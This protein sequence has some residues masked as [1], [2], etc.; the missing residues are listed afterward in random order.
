MRYEDFVN[1]YKVQL[2]NYLEP[3]KVT[4]TLECSNKINQRQEVLAVRF[5]NNNIAPI[6]YIENEFEKYCNG[7]SIDELVYKSAAMLVDANK[8]SKTIVEKT[9]EYDKENLYVV[10][11]NA[12]MNKEILKDVPHRI[13]EDLAVVPRYSLTDEASYI[14]KENLLPM[15]NMT[16]EELL[17]KAIANTHS[18]GYSCDTLNDVVYK[19]SG[20]DMEWSEPEVYVV[21][22][23]RGHD[24][25]IAV[26]D[27]DYMKNVVGEKLGEDFYI[28]PSSRHE[29]L[30]MPCSMEQD[31]DYIR[32][33]VQSINKEIVETGDFLSDNIYLYDL[34]RNTFRLISDEKTIEETADIAK[35]NTQ[36]FA[37]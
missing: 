16:A 8:V 17:D 1:E 6:I 15:F 23:K 10:L 7:H 26:I 2:E 5:D 25:A 32:S 13:V 37:I 21:T 36:T 9:Y 11:I 27:K 30:A 4:V 14:V 18:C 28:L 35:E 29:I 3:H 20:V 34:N 19:L 31:V 24:G 33:V 22:S 12:E